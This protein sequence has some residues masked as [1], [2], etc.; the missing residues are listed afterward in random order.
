MQIGR[1]EGENETENQANNKTNNF[2]II[3]EQATEAMQQSWLTSM[4]K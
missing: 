4:R 3:I 2:I 1:A